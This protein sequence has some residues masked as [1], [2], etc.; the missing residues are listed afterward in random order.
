MGRKTHS[1]DSI[2]LE[3]K[4]RVFISIMVKKSQTR[5]FR[6]FLPR[7]FTLHTT[8]SVWNV[9][10][11]VKSYPVTELCELYADPFAHHDWTVTEDN[12]FAEALGSDGLGFVWRQDDVVAVLEVKPKWGQVVVGSRGR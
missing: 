5:P 12:A 11:K 1:E 2:P 8:K 4:C 7:N 10:W 6:D 3:R 9:K